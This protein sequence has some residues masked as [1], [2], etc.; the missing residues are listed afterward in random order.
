MAI[1]SLVVHRQQIEKFRGTLLAWYDAHKRDL[2]WR[3]TRDPYR[4]WVSEIMLQQ[5]RVAA[6]LE[7]YARWL[8]RF[9]DV[10]ALSSARE[11]T[12]LAMWSGLG[13]YHRARRMHRAAKEIVR[14]LEG[15]FPCTAEELADLPG[16][17]RYTSAAIASI[18]FGEAVP[19]VDGNVQRVITRLSGEDRADIWQQAAILLSRKR[20]GDF[21]QAMMELGATVCT[22]RSPQ[23]LLCPIATWC[24]TRGVESRP[25][26][27]KR[28]RKQLRYIFAQRNGRV[29]L[30]QRAAEAK[31]MASMWELP[32]VAPVLPLLPRQE[33]AKFRHSIT[34]TDYDV[35]VVADDRVDQRHV[36]AAAQW[37]TR[38]QWQRLPLTGLTRKVLFRLAGESSERSQP[39]KKKGTR[40]FPGSLSQSGRKKGTTI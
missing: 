16:I 3:Q 15:K 10:R 4:I 5:T 9:P 32:N 27:P 17:G 36:P 28:Q 29:L 21:N 13:Y 22:P 26:Q 35:T 30:L 11:Q 23:C 40:R 8:K 12:V 20:P 18:A 1:A 6:V 24:A 2:P 39:S 37:F 33:L 31:L 25:T 38:K 7:H 34:N 14:K 19:V